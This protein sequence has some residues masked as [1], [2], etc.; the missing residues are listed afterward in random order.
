MASEIPW[1]LV[2]GNSANVEFLNLVDCADGQGAVVCQS[3]TVKQK[4]KSEYS[5][6]YRIKPK[7]ANFIKCEYI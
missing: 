2:E 3:Q 4:R 5:V 7:A 1:R 6:E